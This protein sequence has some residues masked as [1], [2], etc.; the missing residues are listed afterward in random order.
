MRAVFREA[1]GLVQSDDLVI[2]PDMLGVEEVRVSVQPQQVHVVIPRVVGGGLFTYVR[3]VHP[4]QI[5][6]PL[7][8][9]EVVEHVSP[10]GD[11]GLGFLRAPPEPSTVH[12]VKRPPQHHHARILE[13][14]QSVRYKIKFPNP[15]LVRVRPFLEQ[16]CD[17][18]ALVA[19]AA[20]LGIGRIVHVRHNAHQ[21]A[22]LPVLDRGGIGGLS[23]YTSP[24]KVCVVSPH[25]R[26]PLVRQFVNP[27]HDPKVRTVSEIRELPGNYPIVSLARQRIEIFQHCLD[28][29][30][31]LTV[32][33]L[34][35]PG[36]R[37][38]NHCNGPAHHNFSHKVSFHLMGPK[39]RSLFSVFPLLFVVIAMPKAIR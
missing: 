29:W 6:Q 9:A 26:R 34:D 39:V 4:E 23:R 20:A 21:P 15:A 33:R 3:P 5:V 1:E 35:R 30:I 18:D 14:E 19:Q 22:L 28:L 32:R 12:L 25:Q 17:I 16:V 27:I 10:Y 38:A 7:G 36:R 31:R 11:E 24:S 37:Y 2:A 13:F 8:L